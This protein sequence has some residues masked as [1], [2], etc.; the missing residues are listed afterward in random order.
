MV[1]KVV[2]KGPISKIRH[3]FVSKLYLDLITLKMTMPVV[4]FFGTSQ[5]RYRA[6][7]FHSVRLKVLN[8]FVLNLNVAGMI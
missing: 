8:L 1:Q 7:K 6:N 2:E 3:V 4:C 5:N